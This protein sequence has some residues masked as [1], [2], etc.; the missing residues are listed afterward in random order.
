M[1]E[2][3]ILARTGPLCY[4]IDTLALT[5]RR[6]HASGSGIAAR[7]FLLVER[8]YYTIIRS[9]SKTGS[10]R[11]RGRWFISAGNGAQEC[12]AG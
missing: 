1:K 3:P 2:G 9:Q 7:L 8:Y 11:V 5:P 12:F 4:A 6:G 10:R